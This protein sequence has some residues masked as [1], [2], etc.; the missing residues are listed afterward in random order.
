MLKHTIGDSGYGI[1]AIFYLTFIDT[2]G[3]MVSGRSM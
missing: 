1:Y 3:L 2:R